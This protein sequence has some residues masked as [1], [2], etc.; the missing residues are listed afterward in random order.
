MGATSSFCVEPSGA[1]ALVKHIIGRDGQDRDQCSD[2]TV[3]DLFLMLFFL[4][5]TNPEASMGI[6]SDSFQKEHLSE[7]LAARPPRPIPLALLKRRYCTTMV[8]IIE[9]WILQW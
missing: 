9:G 1:H 6:V 8:A 4:S 5:R 3:C 2:S 7:P